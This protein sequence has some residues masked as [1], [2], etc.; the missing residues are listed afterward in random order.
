VA[1]CCPRLRCLRLSGLREVGA[2][3][4]AALARH[5]P[6]LHDLAFLDCLVLDETALAGL[7]SLR[8][9]SVAGCT[10]VKWATASE[11]WAQL[12][13]LAAL[14]V[15]RTDVSPGAVSRLVSHSATLTLICALNCPSLEEE[16]ARS[17]AAF[18]NSKGKL[19]LTINSTLSE[20]IAAAALFPHTTLVKA[21][22]LFDDDC[23]WSGGVPQLMTWLE[24]VLSQSFLRIA[25]T[26]PRGM[27]QFWLDQGTAL[28]LSLLKSSQEDV[29]ERAATTL[30]AFAVVDDHNAN[31]DPARSEAVM[32]E[33]GIPMLL[34]LARRSRE[35]LQ[36][37][38][39]KVFCNHLNIFKLKLPVS[40]ISYAFFMCLCRQS[41]TYPSIQRLQKQL[42]IRVVLPYS[43]TW[44]SRPTGWLLKKLLVGYGISQL[45]KNTRL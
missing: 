33:G 16:E 45:E 25:E 1:L 23:H 42:Q 6:L 19:V 34:D 10:G 18:A 32:R 38:A 17:P 29:Q 7:V 5:C 35:T 36:S 13:S 26:N 15:S 44:Q 30:A 41:P 21:T 37:E 8:F 2:G 40:I 12:P 20:S 28:L 22:E 31:V 24:W 9:L 3:A 14:D 11:A 43:L 27:N 39:A 4:L